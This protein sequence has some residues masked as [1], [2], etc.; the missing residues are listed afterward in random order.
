MDDQ[1]LQQLPRIAFAV[2]LVGIL[3]MITRLYEVMIWRP[4]RLRGKLLK[5]G[6]SGPPPS[7][8]LGNLPEMKRFSSEP[9]RGE[10][11]V[12]DGEAK[13]G[14][15]DQDSRVITHNCSSKVYPFLE[16][17]RKEYG[18]RIR[19]V[20][21][22][23]VLITFMPMYDLFQAEMLHVYDLDTLK[24]MTM[25][26]S[27]DL[28]RPSNLFRK[29]GPLLGRGVLTSNGTQWA[30]QRKIIAP[31]LYADKVKGMISLMVQSSMTLVK[32]W[33][34]MMDRSEGGAADIKIDAFMR[35]FSGD[36]I[37]RACFGSSFCEGEQI[38]VKLREPSTLRHNYLCVTIIRQLPTKSNR[39]IW[40]LEKEVWSLILKVVKEREG[41]K[42]EKDLLQMILDGAKDGHLSS[43]EMDR[44]IVDN[45][46]NIY[47]AGYE[48]TAVVASWTLM[49]LASNSDWQA[50]VREEIY[51][52]CAGQPPNSATIRNMKTEQ[53]TMVIH[54]SLRLYPPV[55]IFSREAQQDIKFGDV[56]VPKGVTVWAPV[57]T[58]H[59][60]PDIWGPNAAL[61]CPERFS[62]GV[63]ASCRHP[64][65]YM[66][67]GVGPRICLGQNLAMAEL[68][69]VLSIILSN[70]AFSLSPSY[71][72]SPVMRLVIEPE[73]GINL[74]VKKL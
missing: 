5:Q 69:V 17:W 67:F 45:C 51:Q 44:F 30:H 40:R 58:L 29:L 47:Q 46:K 26:T 73:H 74:L 56:L 34:D 43:N 22:S 2:A 19:L 52:V 50:K 15:R 12:A 25:C 63:S 20:L 14:N 66:P 60:N 49:L 8:I 24:E 28:G 21:G 59:I 32:S 37:S 53:M 35:S 18:F 38:F 72:H 7:I 11:Q 1:V 16:R 54:K 57:A 70:F 6:I 3:S 36:V 31:E 48:T 13:I 27:L 23:L 39:A 65:V 64:H 10:D 41:A 62:N 9:Q 71:N 4:K 61:F 33:V 42:S 55:A 68:K